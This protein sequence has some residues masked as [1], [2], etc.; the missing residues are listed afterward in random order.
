MVGEHIS[1]CH[2]LGNQKSPSLQKGGCLVSVNDI[3][4]F[5]DKYLSQYWQVHREKVGE[6]ALS[7]HITCWQVVHFESIR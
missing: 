7:E 6:G 1:D 4:L 5:S 2:G 3:D